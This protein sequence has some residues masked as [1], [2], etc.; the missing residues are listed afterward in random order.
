MILRSTN[1]ESLQK[2]YQKRVRSS[3]RGRRK[4]KNALCQGS[5][6]KILKRKKLVSSAMLLRSKIRTG[7]SYLNLTGERMI[8]TDRNSLNWNGQ[9]GKPDWSGLKRE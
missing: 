6:Q 8:A 3:K 7:R 2:T 4:S 5:K 1:K 9:E